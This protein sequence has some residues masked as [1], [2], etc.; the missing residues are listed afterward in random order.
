MRPQNWKCLLSGPLKKMFVDPCITH[1]PSVPCCRVLFLYR[2][3]WWSYC[4]P[5]HPLI[6]FVETRA[7]CKLWAKP[8]CAAEGGLLGASTHTHSKHVSVTSCVAGPW[9]AARAGL[10]LP[11]GIHRPVGV[12]DIIPQSHRWMYSGLRSQ[13]FSDPLPITPALFLFVTL[14]KK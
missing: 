3:S 1:F 9:L 5:H 14:F 7:C 11:S 6:Y 4:L 10:G 8:R 2:W 13:A 12:L